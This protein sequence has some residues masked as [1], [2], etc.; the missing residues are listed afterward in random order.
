MLL[1]SLCCK[2]CVQKNSPKRRLKTPELKYGSVSTC[3]RTHQPRQQQRQPYIDISYPETIVTYLYH[4]KT[5]TT[6]TRVLPISKQ[7]KNTSRSTQ[8]ACVNNKAIKDHQKLAHKRATTWYTKDKRNPRVFFPKVV[9]KNPEEEYWWSPTTW[10]IQRHVK[11]DIYTFS[12][13][14]TGYTDSIH[15]WVFKTLVTDF[16]SYMKINQINGKVDEN[17]KN[18]LIIRVNKNMGK[19]DTML[20]HQ[21]VNKLLQENSYDILAAKKN[22]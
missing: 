3:N 22:M 5:S 1:I 6:T 16:E 2:R 4:P 7:Q 11:Y 18:N 10:K 12:P 15:T 21:L 8:Q 17:T 20:L 19:E 13:L 9:N 14:N